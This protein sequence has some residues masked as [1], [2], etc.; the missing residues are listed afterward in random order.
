[1]PYLKI[2]SN[3]SLTPDEE[4]ALLTRL[5]STVAAQLGKPEHYVMIAL[6]CTVPMCFA[7]NSAP[8][9]YLELKSL[10]LDESTT[11]TLSA[12]LCD[13]VSQALSIPGDRIYIEFASPLATCG[14][15]TAEPF[16]TPRFAAIHP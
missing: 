10:S 16:N 3:Q 13:V 15:G 1:M 7:G 5:S 2:Q 6:E 8:T 9:A 12:A 4:A 11:A 14:A